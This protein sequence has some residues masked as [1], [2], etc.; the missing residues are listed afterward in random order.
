MSGN[1]EHIDNSGDTIKD[2][3]IIIKTGI[4]E[5]ADRFQTEECITCTEVSTFPAFTY[6][7][8]FLHKCSIQIQKEEKFLLFPVSS[9][10]LIFSI[11]DDI[12]I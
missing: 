2:V 1:W 9:L 6:S 5:R 11:R 3:H 12:D 7:Q 8:C 10:D 4:K